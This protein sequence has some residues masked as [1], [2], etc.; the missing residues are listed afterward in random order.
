MRYLENFVWESKAE[1]FELLLLF[2]YSL[3]ELR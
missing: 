1:F 2:T 3:K